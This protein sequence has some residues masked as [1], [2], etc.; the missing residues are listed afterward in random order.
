MAQ[1]LDNTI[2]VE[3]VSTRQLSASFA[4]KLRRI[5]DCTELVFVG[6]IEVAGGFGAAGLEARQALALVG[7]TLACMATI[8][9]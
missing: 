1:E 4:A 2:S 5:A 9:V 8:T 6:S 3:D 7:D